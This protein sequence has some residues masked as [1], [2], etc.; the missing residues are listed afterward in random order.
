MEFTYK[1]AL[2]LL[3]SGASYLVGGFDK[4][5]QI[6]LILVVIDYITGMIR[7]GINKRLDS[8]IGAK[9]IYRKMCIFIVIAVAVL[10]EQFIGKPE[11]IH[12]V[13]AYFYVVNEAISILEN[14]DEYVPIP[15]PLRQLLNRLKPKK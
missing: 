8:R 9:G 12:N 5:I 11:T 4:A 13:V 15:E 14:V 10:I 6:L 7:A 2:T 1:S 3:V